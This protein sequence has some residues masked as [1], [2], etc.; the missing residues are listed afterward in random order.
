MMNT[1]DNEFL[2]ESKLGDFL[3]TYHPIKNWT[4]QY[5][6]GK[7]FRVDWFCDEI[8]T[9]VEFDGYQHFTSSR[10]IFND[11]RKN[12]LCNELGISIIRIPYFVQL[13]PETI[14]LLFQFDCPYVQR[15]PH[16]FISNKSTMIFPAD[17]CE[18]GIARFRDEL[19]KFG[20]AIM[21]HIINSLH[22]A[23]AN[24][25]IETVIPLSCADLLTIKP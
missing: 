2:T 4:S 20:Q 14:K 19:Q 16:G 7:R 9:A 22:R 25:P 18:L 24:H 10:Q 5:N 23:I 15:Y 11:K 13:S 21:V 8:K 6:L 3:K 12:E 1:G 17:F